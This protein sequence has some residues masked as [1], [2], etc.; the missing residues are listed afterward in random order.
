MNAIAN[1]VSAMAR[2]TALLLVAAA[3]WA[4]AAQGA[5]KLDR[6]VLPIAE[7]KPAVTTE[8]DAR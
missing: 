4:A 2:I 1:T 6:S 5:D 3:H 8:I 7:P